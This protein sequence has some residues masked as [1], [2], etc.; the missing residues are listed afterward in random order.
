[1]RRNDYNGHHDDDDDDDD[2]DVRYIL[3]AAAAVLPW[4]SVALPA[5]FHYI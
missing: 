4:G 3:E 2:D 5:P 1:M